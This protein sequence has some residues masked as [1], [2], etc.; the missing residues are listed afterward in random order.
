METARH[1]PG[2][3][4][5]SRADRTKDY[6]YKKEFYRSREVARD[7]DAHRFGS[8]KRARRN[9]KKW[10]T[11]LRALD[12]TDGVSSILDLPCGTGRFTGHLA[13]VGY[14]VVGSDISLDMM[15]VARTTIGRLPGLHGYLQADAERLPMR[16]D[17]VDCVMSIRFLFH[18]DSATRVR[19]LR[20]FGRVSRRWLILDYR[21]KYS[22]RYATWTIRRL[23]GLTRERLDRVSRRQ[24][25]QEMRD[26]G[27]RILNVF[28]VTRVFS[29]K[30]I[31]V[32]EIGVDPR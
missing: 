29:D 22:F 19:M 13:D 3:S 27:L 17:S 16:E 11:I 4:D 10:R 9:V 6:A 8:P 25:E 5:P 30:W 1:K 15:Q 21:H 20:E 12:R 7:Y 26:A 24:M 31:V 18:V 23:L 32:G 2:K 28:P 14:E